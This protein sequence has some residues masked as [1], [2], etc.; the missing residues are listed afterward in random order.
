[1]MGVDNIHTMNGLKTLLATCGN[2]MAILMFISA[3]AIYWPQALLMIVGAIMGGYGGA[4]FAQKLNP[5]TVR[6]LVIGI[7]CTMTAYFF[8]KTWAR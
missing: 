3:H 2:A 8:W 5:R 4:Y 1:M 6:W 7:G